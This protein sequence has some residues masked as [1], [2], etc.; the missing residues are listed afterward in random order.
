MPKDSVLLFED[1]TELHL[2]PNIER[3]WQSCQERILAAGQDRK[4]NLFGVV[5]YETEEVHHRHCRRKRG[6]D[7]IGFLWQ[8]L[9][10]YPGKKM[11]IVLDNYV[12]HKTQKVLELLQKIGERIRL[13]FLPTQKWDNQ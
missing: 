12:I 13:I 8:L 9:R 10:A 6:V 1:E 4:I 5:N 7:F 3:K 11:L 2:N